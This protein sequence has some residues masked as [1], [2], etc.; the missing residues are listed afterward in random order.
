M[1]EWF[2]VFFYCIFWK[3]IVILDN[4]VYSSSIT[5]SETK[6]QFVIHKTRNCENNNDILNWNFHNM[7]K[8]HD[9][10]FISWTLTRPQTTQIFSIKIV[11][12][13]LKHSCLLKTDFNYLMWTNP[14][15]WQSSIS[16]KLGN[17][18]KCLPCR[19]FLT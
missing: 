5:L 3:I 1:V 11:S 13:W 8:S 7:C 19:L 4:A 17:I 6:Y 14:L 15:L 10:Y 2:L 16:K 9:T 18:S 12:C